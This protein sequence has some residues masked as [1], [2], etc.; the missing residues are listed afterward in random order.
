MTLL[1]WNDK[2]SVGVPALDEDHKRLIDIINR[3]EKAERTGDSVKWVL[4]DLAD[5]AHYHFQ[6]EEDRLKTIDYPGLADHMGK[7]E[8]FVE[9]LET[10]SKTYA[11]APE[12]HFHQA[13]TVRDY[14]KNWLINHILGTDMEYKDYLS[15]Q[16]N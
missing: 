14:L 10:L 3:V 7:H 16:D 15:E 8:A 11:M 2:Y 5:Y 6:Q 12:A 1:E 13:E 4:Q 9:W